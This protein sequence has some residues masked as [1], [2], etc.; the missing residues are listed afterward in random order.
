VAN[1]VRIL[2]LPADIKEALRAGK[3]ARTHA[4]A[5]LSFKDESK[6]R[7]MFKQ[8]LA[9][10]FAVRELETAAREYHATT[11]SAAPAVS[12]RFQELQQNLSKNLGAAV[13]IK[14]GAS[15]GSI[16]IKFTNLEELN[17]IAKV[18]LD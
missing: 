18:I 15:G 8:I 4:R 10:N 13:F 14:S 1:A 2:A 3:I 6:Q 16:V 5:L 9:G 12:P 7:E 11:K 17:S